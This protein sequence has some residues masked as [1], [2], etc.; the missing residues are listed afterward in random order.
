MK[1]TGKLAKHFFFRPG[2]LPPPTRED[3][4]FPDPPEYLRNP[5]TKVRF[6]QTYFLT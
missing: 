1:E 2:D 4:D 6:V 5:F 3:L